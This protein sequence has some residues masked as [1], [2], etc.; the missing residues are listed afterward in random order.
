V[1]IEFNVCIEDKRKSNVR[2]SNR[3]IV[4]SNVEVVIFELLY[5]YYRI[6]GVNILL[7]ETKML[8]FKKEK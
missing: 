5:L 4:K 6:N 1:K 8:M 3:F 7:L 2:F